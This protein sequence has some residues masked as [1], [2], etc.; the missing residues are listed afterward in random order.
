MSRIPAAPSQQ[1]GVG[2]LDLG[3]NAI[4][5]AVT[6][7]GQA[8]QSF[9]VQQTRLEQREQLFAQKEAERLQKQMVRLAE[10]SR[11]S[12]NR[13]L[14]LLKTTN[15]E[16]RIRSVEDGF[17]ADTSIEPQAIMD[18]FSEAS[19][20]ILA[21]AVDGIED[22]ETREQVQ[23]SVA[24]SLAQARSRTLV[25]AVGREGSMTE[26]TISNA[27]DAWRFGMPE[28][29]IPQTIAGN[30]SIS[31]NV[32][33]AM[34][35]DWQKKRSVE[36][37]DAF[38]AM[39]SRAQ[40]SDR[41]VQLIE[42]AR[43][44]KGGLTS[45]QF[46]TSLL[47]DNA[48]AE[49]RKPEPDIKRFGT[50]AGMVREF[51]PD[52]VEEMANR[53]REK[54][55]QI[56]RVSS[57]VADA[58]AGKDTYGGAAPSQG[59]LNVVWDKVVAEMPGDSRE[60]IVGAV[61]FF[62]AHDN[63]LGPLPTDGIKAIGDAFRKGSGRFDPALGVRSLR[64]LRDVGGGEN[65]VN[66]IIASLGEDAQMAMVAYHNTLG[67]DVKTA[68]F[69]RV[70]SDL[71]NDAAPR[72]MAEAKLNMVGGRDLGD[73]KE[74]APMDVAKVMRGTVIGENSVSPEVT[75][76]YDK[77]WREFNA[78]YS[79]EMLRSSLSTGVALTGPLTPGSDMHKIAAT[80]ATDRMLGVDGKYVGIEV[81]VFGSNRTL[82]AEKSVY[83][84]MDER[85]RDRFQAA[86][87]QKLRH[88][89]GGR[90]TDPDHIARLDKGFF[91]RNGI[92]A[93]PVMG[94]T[95]VK[96]FALWDVEQSRFSGTVGPGQKVTKSGS[97]RLGI[98]EGDTGLFD[99][100]M[101]MHIRKSGGDP[102]DI[103]SHLR[104]LPHYKSDKLWEVDNENGDLFR[105]VVRAGILKW[106]NRLNGG[107]APVSD[108]DFREA[109]EFT[110][111]WA[112]G[113][114]MGWSELR[115]PKD[116]APETPGDSD[117]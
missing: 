86:V 83:G 79:Y 90:F 93:I 100:L 38:A 23:A 7:L 54:H 26:T 24:K 11:K 5:A 92:A 113:P 16:L 60:A 76:V 89:M 22:P 112:T 19:Q 56:D 55:S 32:R 48:D 65:R 66:R 117:Q 85:S 109:M 35:E 6:D 15:A 68:S 77:Q 39:I 108:A 116:S 87:S 78:L 105:A 41:I 69:Q 67:M 88:Q 63:G 71:S 40:D 107:A 61:T 34:M 12:R 47:L 98:K 17:T 104:R 59:D 18:G 91:F 1:L 25:T 30:T 74:S 62:A 64:A 72:V 4:G 96:R 57:I 31:D 73:G 80:R 13:R 94:D 111:K 43:D 51:A 28:D 52:T 58:R 3:G 21:E 53:V 101:S 75:H 20:D 99:E 8:G 110:Q 95:G 97:G 10:E 2:G 45:K 27:I 44:Y 33:Q 36:G 102:G 14:R 50:L 84:I 115:K 114:G 103:F 42:Q 37:M 49:S 29:T 46:L 81:S 9:A 106:R 82:M 70:M